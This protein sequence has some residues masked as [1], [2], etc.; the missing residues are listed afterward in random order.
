M[1]LYIAEKPSVGQNIADALGGGKRQDGY[2]ECGNSVVTWCFGHLFELAEPDEYLPDDIPTVETKEGVKKLWR[3]EDLPIFPEDWILKPKEDAKKQ[4]KIIKGLLDR[5]TEIVNAGDTDREGQLLVDE[6]LE[7]YGNKKPVLRY[8]SSAHDELSAKKAIANLKSNTDY[9]ALG[10]SAKARQ[11]ADWLIGMN[12]SRA[13]TLKASEGGSRAKLSVGRVQTPTLALIVHR[14]EAIENFKAIPFFTLSAE[15]EKDGL[16]FKAK[17]IAKEDQ[18]GL[19]SEGRL[20]NEDV[21]NGLVERLK[22]KTATITN[23]KKEAQKKGQPL[24]LSLTRVASLASAKWGYTQSDTLKICQALYETHKLTT[25]PRTDCDYLPEVQHQDAPQI[26]AAVA[27]NNPNF[28]ALVQKA[29]PSIKSKTWDDSK[30]TAHY[31]I[32]PTAHNAADKK[33]SQQ[34]QNIY[35]LVCAYYLAQFFPVAEYSKIS[36]DVDIDSESFKTIVKSLIKAGWTEVLSNENEEEGDEENTSNDFS[37]LK[38]G[39]SLNCLDVIKNATKTKAPPR[40]TE[41]NLG[42]A[43]A[44][45]HRYIEDDSPEGDLIKKIL[46]DGEGIGTTATRAAIIEELKKRGFIE[47]KGKAIVS[48]PLGRSVVHTLPTTVRSAVLTA[49]NEREL[50]NIVDGK[51]DRDTFVKSMEDYVRKE[52]EKVRDKNI[53]IVGGAEAPA[54]SAFK[55]LECQSGLIRREAKKKKGAFYWSCSGYPKCDMTYMDAKG[56]PNYQ[57]PL[58]KG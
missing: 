26:L 12:L 20:V 40:F 9:G 46:K 36:I 35:D 49:L 10:E 41:G 15:L 43:M 32:I 39:D 34:E 58:K 52:I 11:Y 30:V 27:R 8:W 22:G 56:R 47:N 38:N 7:F 14:D 16:Q 33:L 24:S 54:I 25:Y 4:L 23:L 3:F 50:K 19:D 18:K 21:A 37:I 48:T 53:K 28:A 31:G 51:S 6:V 1:R 13:Y 55:C 5:A 2:I 17:W 44:N 29:D 45:I 42:E 57:K